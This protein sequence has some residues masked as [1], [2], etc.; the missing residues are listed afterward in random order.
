MKCEW[1]S[2]SKKVANKGPSVR[3]TRESV[4]QVTFTAVKQSPRGR[5]AR[6]AATE[7]KWGERR[8]GLRVRA[9]MDASDEDG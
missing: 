3:S 7:I 2:L 5:G 4:T 1:G 8:E 6:R 9:I